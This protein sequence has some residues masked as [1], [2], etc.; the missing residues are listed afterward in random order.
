MPRFAVLLHDW[1]EPHFDL[2]LGDGDELQS[3]KLPGDFSP[4]AVSPIVPGAA[5]RSLYLDYEGAVSGGRGTVV[6][7]DAGEFEWL[8][9]QRAQFFGARLHGIYTWI[10]TADG[11]WTFGPVT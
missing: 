3:W 5:H 8:A 10:E 9:E 7:W 4:P 6:R 11:A 2:F 1:P